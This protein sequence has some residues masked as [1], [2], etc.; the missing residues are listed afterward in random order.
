[1]Q[2]RS[3]SLRSLCPIGHRTL[4][5]PSRPVRIEH[6]AGGGKSLLDFPRQNLIIMRKINLGKLRCSTQSS[7]NG[8][9][10]SFPSTKSQT[11]ATISSF[12]VRKPCS[13]SK[14]PDNTEAK[15]PKV[16][17]FTRLRYL[18]TL[19]NLVQNC[20]FFLYLEYLIF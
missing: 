12:F 16:G 15:S 5:T 13:K 18:L 6:F 2:S 9:S 7:A 8:H 10:P 3:L 4:P 1:M 11:Q 17:L 20:I 14:D 19:T